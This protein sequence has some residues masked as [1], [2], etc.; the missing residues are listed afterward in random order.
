M[1]MMNT[2]QPIGR[3]V[4]LAGW[5][6]L[7]T[8]APLAH[9]QTAGP[10]VG[11]WNVARVEW[12]PLGLRSVRLDGFL[13]RHVDANNRLS[14]L[15]GLESPMPRA[16]DALAAGQTPPPETRRLA[17][18]SDF[19]KWLE[20]ACYALAYEPSLNELAQAVERYAGIFIRLQE[21][22]GF[23]GTRLSPAEPFD[24]RVRHDLYC[25]GHFVE[26]AVAHYH[27]TGRR[28]LL[29]AAMRFV[30]FYYRAWKD[31]HPYFEIVGTQEHAEIEVALAR[32]Y[33]A[34]GEPR[35]LEFG[36]AITRMAHLAGTLAEVRA[37]DGSLHAVRLCYLLTGATEL[38]MESGKE[39][40]FQ[41]VP[42]L[43]EEIITTRMYVTGG[44]GWNE[45]VPVTPYDLPHTLVGNSHR[46]IAETC[47]SVSLMMLSW[48]LHA[49]NG[50]PR[51]YDAIETILYN[52]YLGAISQDHLAVFYYNPLRRVGD[53]TGKTDHSADPV[54]RRRLPQIHS[55]A[56]CLP[57]A[58]RFFGQLP[59]YVFS[60]KADELRVNLYTDARTSYELGDGTAVAVEVATE[61]PH[62]GRVKVKVQPAR[63]R[64]FA[65]S[66]RVPAWCPDA[67][68][69]VGG[70]LVSAAPGYHTIEREWHG[71]DVVE[72]HLPMRPVVLTSH[73][74]VSA[75]IGQV[76]F[77][78]GPLVYCLERQDA[79]GM[80]VEDVAVVLDAT[81]PADL[82]RERFD[83]EHGYYVLRVPALHRPSRPA[84]QPALYEPQPARAMSGLRD[85]SLI[86]FYFRANREGDTR[87]ITWLPYEAR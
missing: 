44:I 5:T 67:T 83:K 82:I 45:R 41:Y 56:C 63:P 61:Y 49:L 81:H 48:R 74:A 60:R 40:L 71:G 28:D 53:L 59:E 23:L 47:A 7:V 3:R 64:S 9:G 27:A 58:W 19:Y 6:L 11:N 69:S 13:G 72:L 66:L 39:D 34:T 16:F 24:R 33:R 1:N 46:D 62:D 37:G 30:D 79:A 15:Q 20:G 18:D 12:M 52:H 36:E 70:K 21:P 4:A 31:K 17:T 65:I 38:S 10:C 68:V 25:A 2:L 80:D 57:N 50:D 14:L 84:T 76:A 22:D 73:P 85:V 87:W 54:Q 32:L 77:R 29:E 51:C 43:W 55:T 42:K 75:N 8:T 86:P 26:A 35:F 78:R